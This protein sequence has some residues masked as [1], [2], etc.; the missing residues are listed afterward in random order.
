MNNKKLID[1]LPVSKLYFDKKL[2]LNVSYRY[3]EENKKLPILFLHGFNGNSKSWAHQFKY[4]KNKRSVIAIDFPGFGNST[5]LDTDMKTIADMFIRL[6]K[7]LNISRFQIVG[8]SMGGMLAQ[9]MAINYEKLVNKLILSCTH[10]GFAI[11]KEKPLGI[12]YVK[13][14]EQRKKLTNQEFG[15]IR[16]SK[17]L[18]E[19]NIINKETFKFLTSISEEITVGAISAGGMA[20]QTLDTSKNLQN[21]STECLI[22]TASQDII[23]SEQQKIALRN[24]LPKAITKEILNVGHAPYCEDPESFN[25]LLKDFL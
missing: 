19:S 24:S 6:L 15:K 7:K 17:M 13:R 20:M 18:S 1:F 10:N 9:V 14:I 21:L 2:G 3:V 22:I 11:S 4:F 16:V 23:V 5:A 8:H 12:D 25:N